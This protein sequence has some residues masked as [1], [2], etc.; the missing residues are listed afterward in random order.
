MTLHRK[1]VFALLGVAT[2]CVAIDSSALTLGRA[3]GA[4]FL[5]QALKLTVPAQVES[6]EGASALCFEADVFYGDI[7][8]ETSRVA[9]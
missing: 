4:V 3:K 8:Q 5:G 9:G 6:G 1:F 7:R 2:F